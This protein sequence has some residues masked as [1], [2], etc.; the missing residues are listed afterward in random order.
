MSLP[1]PRDV[2]SPE[3]IIAAIYETISGRASEERD[4]DR[5]RSLHASDARLMP[6]ETDESGV[7]RPRMFSPD[8]FI[9]SRR[10]LLAS[11]DF[12]EWET[13]REERRSGQMVHVWSSYDASRT[14]QGKPIRRA[15]NS[16]QLW[17][18]GSRWWIISVM[19]DAE[20]AKAI[21]DEP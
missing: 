15:V 17:D 1:R 9:E 12:Y 21:S 3:A 10:S 7:V 13:A 2:G 11:D 18:D 4:W 8:E 20:N 14:P 19:W 6:I 5:L 16:I